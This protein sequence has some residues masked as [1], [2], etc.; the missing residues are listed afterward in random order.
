M[1]ETILLILAIYLLP[2]SA[3]IAFAYG[4]DRWLTRSLEKEC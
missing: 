4:M 2:P 1:L 3:V